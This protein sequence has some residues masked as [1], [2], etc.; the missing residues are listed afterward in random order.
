MKILP[1]IVDAAMASGWYKL[2]G[3]VKATSPVD[4]LKGPGPFT[5]FNHTDK[6]LNKIPKADMD[7][8]MNTPMKLEEVLT[9]YVFETKNE[10]CRFEGT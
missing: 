10:G 5:V 9:F 8:L 6:A 1:D 3:A 7:M 4:T 2:V